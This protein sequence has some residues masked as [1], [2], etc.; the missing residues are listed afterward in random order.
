VE[1]RNGA[2]PN[3]GSSESVC[4]VADAARPHRPRSYV[5]SD[6]EL[7]S[8]LNDDS[9]AGLTGAAAGMAVHI[10]AAES[11]H[12]FCTRKGPIQSARQGRYVAKGTTSS[13]TTTTAAS[14]P[15]ATILL[16]PVLVS[17]T[18]TEESSSSTGEGL[19]HPPSG[20][21]AILQ[22]PPRPWPR[23]DEQYRI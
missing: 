5:S 6:L 19:S 18:K 12:Y 9:C 4:S 23:G 1:F 15:R 7:E 3:I 10:S 22:P 16:S 17:R 13:S 14:A 11:R 21:E 20:V 2:K 8:S